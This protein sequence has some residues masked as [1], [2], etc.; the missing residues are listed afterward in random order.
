[1][2][3]QDDGS[4]E[5]GVWEGCRE[6]T[7]DDLVS[8]VISASLEKNSEFRTDDAGL[9]PTRTSDISWAPWI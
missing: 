3:S 5:N 9:T 6:Y 8:D 7:C 4:E 1:M 2:P